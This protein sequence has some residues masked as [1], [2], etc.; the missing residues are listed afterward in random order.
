MSAAAH[1][2]GAPDWPLHGHG[3]AEQR[4]SPLTSIDRSNVDRLGLAFEFSDFVVRG[5]T[6]RG[7]EA[8]PLAV[9][10]R[11]YFTGPWSVVYALD[12]VTG[13][14]LWTYDPGVPGQWLRKACCD[15]VNRGV[16]ILG[17]RVY[18]GT[19]D[20]YLDAL[21]IESGERLWRADTLTQRSRAYTITGAPRIAGDRILIGNGGGELGVRGYVSAYDT[22]GRLAWRFFTVPGPGDDEHPELA[23]ARKTWSENPAWDFGL[24][25]TAWDSMSYDPALG[26]VYVGTG[27]GSPWPAG[28]RSPGGGDNLFLSSILAIE[29]N[30]GRLRWHYQTTPGDSWDYT[31]T[32]QMILVDRRIGGRDRKLIVQAPKNGFFYVLDRVTG[33][34]ISAE[35]YT[36]VSWAGHVD[37][38]TGRP[39]QNPDARYGAARNIVRPSLFG[40]HN[41]QP[42]SYSPATGLVYIPVLESDMEIR[43]EPRP[44]MPDSINVGAAV[45]DA[46]SR[47]A[48]DALLGERRRP[49]SSRLVA[50]DPARQR[51]AWSSLPGTWWNGGVL[52]TAGGLVFQGAAD[53]GLWI[54]DADSGDALRRIETGSAIL[55][56]PISYEVDGAQ[57]IAVLAGFGGAPKTYPPGSAPAKYRNLERL[58]VFGLDGDDVPLPPRV[59]PPEPRAA[60]PQRVFDKALAARGSALFTVH[61]ARCHAPR[62]TPNGYPNLWNLPAPLYDA[63]EPIVLDGA[64]SG[65]GM[66][67]YADV[68]GPADV[69]AIREYLLRDEALYGRARLL[70]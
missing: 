35:P 65:A 53:G 39:V 37:P 24:G 19:L 67:G 57:Y 36:E 70:E 40:G 26:L 66:P 60:H 8:T 9:D 55:A 62:G 31:A 30:T 61:C 56:A 64:L 59:G 18:V 41:W 16:A 5:R 20:G 11:L 1:G 22:D 68:L 4:H 69:A 2:G 43:T 54:Y 13:E 48:A 3:H 15:A 32:Q 52:S 28:Q 45:D 10:G 29:A 51:E 21:D 25:G 58:L 23:Q 6:H 14:R 12:A 63:L 49:P 38:K 46:R 50:W 17:A 47:H 34:L 7:N 27:N 42:M 44:F 33:E